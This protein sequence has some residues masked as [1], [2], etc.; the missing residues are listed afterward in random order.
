MSKGGRGGG[1]QFPYL[2]FYSHTSSF[3]N[4]HFFVHQRFCVIFFWF[5]VFAFISPLS[6]LSSL[7]TYSVFP[8]SFT[9]H[10]CMYIVHCQS[11]LLYDFSPLLYLLLFIY[12]PPL[13][14]LFLYF[15][16]P[17]TFSMYV[18]LPTPPLPFSMY[19]YT[20]HPSP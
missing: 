20:S 9:P 10:P 5:K 13:P 2:S 14:Y 16:P 15:P 4:L 3:T 12:F 19:M 7:S 8:Y 18:I 17:F 6:F 11:S 1:I